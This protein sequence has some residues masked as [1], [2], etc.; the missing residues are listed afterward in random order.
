M[1]FNII[2]AQK[3]AITASN[4]VV[5]LAQMLQ[6]Y[7]RIQRYQK[8]LVPAPRVMSRPPAVKNILGHRPSKSLDVTPSAEAQTL[9]Q[10]TSICNEGLTAQTEWMKPDY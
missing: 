2:L 3:Q 5:T 4:H 6:Y 1:S 8:V 9:T 10:S 7:Q